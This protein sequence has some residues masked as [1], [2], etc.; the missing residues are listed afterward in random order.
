MGS[1]SYDDEWVERNYKKIT[2]LGVKHNKRDLADKAIGEGKSI[3]EFNEQ[4]LLKELRDNRY[5]TAVTVDATGTALLDEILL[6]RRIELW[7]EGFVGLDIKRLKL[8]VDR[9]DSNHNPV[10]AQ[11][12]T[13]AAE[14]PN[15]IYQIPQDE[16]DANDLISEED[17]NK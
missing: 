8:A 2:D 5:N 7:G 13:M 10:Y 9:S 6:E 15:F 12:M 3:E 16:I 4:S 14:S 17:Q 11:N 1:N